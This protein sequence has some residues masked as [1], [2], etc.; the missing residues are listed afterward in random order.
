[1]SQQYYDGIGSGDYETGSY[2]TLPDYYGF[3][4]M[5]ATGVPITSFNANAPRKGVPAVV[6]APFRSA[7]DTLD[8]QRNGMMNPYGGGSGA[9]FNLSTAY[10]SR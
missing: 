2:A 9:Y 8:G 4:P 1:M 7:Y 10:Q 5:L 3:K 6:R